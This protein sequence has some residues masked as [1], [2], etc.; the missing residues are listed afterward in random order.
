MLSH[1]Q[2]H[3]TT[4]EFDAQVSHMTETVKQAGRDEVLAQIHPQTLAVDFTGLAEALSQ[5]QLH[6]NAPWRGEM[7][8]YRES[9]RQMQVS[10]MAAD[11]KDLR[12]EVQRK[13]E[14]NELTPGEVMALQYLLFFDDTPDAA[15]RLL[16][17][18]I[19][20]TPRVYRNKI[21]NWGAIA[22]NMDPGDLCMFGP[23]ITTLDYPLFPPASC[24]EI[25]SRV[26]M[27]GRP[28][29]L[30]GGGS[31]QA[32][33]KNYFSE[34]REWEATTMAGGAHE[35]RGSATD[36][37]HTQPPGFDR[38]LTSIERGIQHLISRPLAPAGS[39][40]AKPQPPVTAQ[41][42]KPKGVWGGGV[43][44]SSPKNA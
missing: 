1:A 43:H 11:I 37:G 40:P 41:P 2:G 9:Y 33:A 5:Q 4:E 23:D 20:R 38:R 26:L 28:M 14:A 30:G 32:V 18:M 22:P 10:V 17:A 13:A 12:A 7:M 3:T 31:Q 35:Q 21:H 34:E 29:Y 6:M 36:A 24:K 16:A 42:P 25:N 39:T 15:R 19:L 8:D 27:A 44:D